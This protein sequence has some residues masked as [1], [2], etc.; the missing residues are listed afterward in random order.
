M[1]LYTVVVH[2]LQMCM[3]EY[4]CCPKFQSSSYI[5][6]T[7]QPTG[8]THR[9]DNPWNGVGPPNT[10]LKGKIKYF[11]NVAVIFGTNII[12]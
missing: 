3:K 7:I 8:I 2:N 11:A 12:M 6:R 9:S 4:R 10:G 5:W 1:K